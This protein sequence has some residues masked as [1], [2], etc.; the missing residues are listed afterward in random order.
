LAGPMVSLLLAASTGAVLLL[1]IPV[2]SLWSVP[3][4][5]T[6]GLGKSFFWIN[7]FFFGINLLPAFPL[8]CGRVLRAWLAR[9]MEYQQATRRSVTIAN[10]FAAAFV[11]GGVG[12]NW[13]TMTGLV[14][15]LAT[16][17]EERTLLFH[18]VAESVLMGDVM[19]THFA[20]LSPADTLEDAL[21]KAVHSL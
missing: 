2:A 10:L 9:R 15:F 19:L 17:M 11:L 1:E 16:Q 20:T 8:D 3:L 5:T 18:S 12:S 6:E 21:S 14:L 4:V 13:L 7:V